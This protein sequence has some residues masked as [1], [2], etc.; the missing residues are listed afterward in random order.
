M[1]VSEEGESSKNQALGK[2]PGLARVIQLD[3]VDGRGSSIPAEQGSF[4]D[5]SITSPPLWKG[6]LFKIVPGIWHKQLLICL[7]L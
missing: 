1:H 4:L 5:L 3:K 6:K 7:S 2:K